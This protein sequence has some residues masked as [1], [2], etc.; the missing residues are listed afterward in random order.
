MLILVEFPSVNQIIINH[1]AYYAFSIKKITPSALHGCKRLRFLVMTSPDFENNLSLGT[2]VA[3]M[4]SI[5][6]ATKA[7]VFN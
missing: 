2:E 6:H 5:L 4:A 7:S 1:K 3:G